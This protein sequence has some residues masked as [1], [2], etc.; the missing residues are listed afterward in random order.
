MISLSA[1]AFAAGTIPPTKQA[2]NAVY[3]NLTS[4]LACLCGCGTTLK[5]C[6]HETCSFAIPVRKELRGLIDQ[7]LSGDEIKAKLVAHHGEAILAQPMFYGFNTLAW[8]TPFLAI[9][10]VGYL[11]ATIIK[12]WSVGK[13]V[14]AAKKPAA[15]SP[16]PDRY[17]EKM[18]EE[19]KKFED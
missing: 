10:V 12:K 8:I 6:P 18:R 4:N 15:T 1:P 9:M 2:G 3:E 5:T 19:L 16:S 11:V 14:P 7:G 17:V 13:T